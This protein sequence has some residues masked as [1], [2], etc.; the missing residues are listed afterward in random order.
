MLRT[1][2]LR[3]EEIVVDVWVSLLSFVQVSLLV[4]P[5]LQEHLQNLLHLQHR[6]SV[7]ACCWVSA[8]FSFLL[9]I[10]FFIEIAEFSSLYTSIVSFG[11]HGKDTLAFSF[12][13]RH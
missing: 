5:E 7:T 13:S 3:T 6:G 12:T 4:Q 8:F 11:W 2:S 9:R 1:A 10:L